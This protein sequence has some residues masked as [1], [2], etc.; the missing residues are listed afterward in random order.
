M[1]D[2][3]TI[4]FDRD[5]VFTWNGTTSGVRVPNGDAIPATARA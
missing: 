4:D 3:S 2:L 1:P 5:V